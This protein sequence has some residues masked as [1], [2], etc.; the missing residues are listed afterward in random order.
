MLKINTTYKKKD[1]KALISQKNSRSWFKAGIIM[2]PRRHTN[3]MR[4]CK[5]RLTQ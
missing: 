3:L 1:L 4:V 2:L 5:Y